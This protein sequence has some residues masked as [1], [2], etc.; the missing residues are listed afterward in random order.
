MLPKKEK[1]TKTYI[2]KGLNIW[3]A[4]FRLIWTTHSCSK[5][6][7]EQ[8]GNGGT[9]GGELDYLFVF[10]QGKLELRHHSEAMT[11]RSLFI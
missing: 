9:W 7:Q 4:H 6:R 8:N 2:E 1:H 3:F 10:Q 11:H 5:G